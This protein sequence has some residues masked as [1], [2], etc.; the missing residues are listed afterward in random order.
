MVE[1]SFK[2]WLAAEGFGGVEPI[3]QDPTLSAKAGGGTTHAFQ[4]AHG[5]R[6]V[7]TDPRNPDGELPPTRSRMKKMK[8]KSRKK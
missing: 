2:Q 4:T 5:P 3:K 6:D 8:K 1:L 7:Q